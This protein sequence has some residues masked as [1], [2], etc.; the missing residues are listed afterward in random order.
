MLPQK[1]SFVIGV[2][3]PQKYKTGLMRSDGEP[4][5][6]TNSGKIEFASSDTWRRTRLR[7]NAG[8]RRAALFAG[9]LTGASQGLLPLVLISGTTLG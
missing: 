6:N 9:R 2:D 7:P 4:G 3:E 5:F 8:L 1:C